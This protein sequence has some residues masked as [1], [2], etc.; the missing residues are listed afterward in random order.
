M[1]ALRLDAATA[2]RVYG[3]IAGDDEATTERRRALRGER[4]GREPGDELAPPAG[5][6][7]VGDLLHVVDGR[8]WCNGADLGPVTASYREGCVL[9]ETPARLIAPE[10]DA[11]DTEIADEIVFRE[12]LCPVTG[13]RVDAEIARAGERVLCDMRLDG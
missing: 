7:A 2:E 6:R 1:A 5:A 8:W 3:V 10:F 13:Y 11:E 9:R 12:Y 4:L